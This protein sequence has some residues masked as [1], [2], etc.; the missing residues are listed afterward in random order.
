MYAMT[1]GSFPSSQKQLLDW[2]GGDTRL[3]HCSEPNAPNYVY[4]PGE[5]SDMPPTT[6]LLYEPAPVHDG[7]CNVLL[8]DGRMETLPPEEVKKAVEA[9]IAML[10]QHI[11]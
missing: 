11:R 8:L 3:F 6:V 5:T 10:K 7:K 4:I 9:T 2:C 1:N